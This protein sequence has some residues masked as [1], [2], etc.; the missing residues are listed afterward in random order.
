MARLHVTD[1]EPPTDA[2]PTAENPPPT[3]RLPQ[4]DS[5]PPKAPEPVTPRSPPVTSTRRSAGSTDI[6]YS[7]TGGPRPMLGGFE[8]LSPQPQP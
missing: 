8:R 6:R 2:E 1:S 7:A 4:A 3:A 5:A